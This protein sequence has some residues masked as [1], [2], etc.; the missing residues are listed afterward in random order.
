MYLFKKFTFEIGDYVVGVTNSSDNRWVE[1]GKLYQ[2]YF[3]F[4]GKHKS[5]DFYRFR[6]SEFKGS[7]SYP[8]EYFR[9]ATKQEYIVAK[10][11]GKLYE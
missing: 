8:S 4:W 3:R 7:V 1:V 6:N 2:I 9:K 11:K 10:L 5:Y